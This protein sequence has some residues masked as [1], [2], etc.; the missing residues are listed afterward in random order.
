[1]KIIERYFKSFNLEI[2]RGRYE[3]FEVWKDFLVFN[4]S[5]SSGSFFK[6]FYKEDQLNEDLQNCIIE[7]LNWHEK[8]YFSKLELFKAIECIFI[9]LKNLEVERLH[10]KPPVSGEPTNNVVTTIK[11]H[12]KGERP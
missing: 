11:E 2:F 6:T 4:I 8:K 5:L 12:M 1:M 7:L 9:Y 10:P 3:E